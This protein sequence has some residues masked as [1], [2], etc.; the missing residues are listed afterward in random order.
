MNIC[1]LRALTL[2]NKLY[3][4]TVADI[5]VAVG[6]DIFVLLKRKFSPILQLSSIVLGSDVGVYVG[7]VV[8]DENG[9]EWYICYESGFVAYSM[10]GERRKL[11]YEFNRMT[12]VRQLTVGERESFGYKKNKLKFKYQE[13]I[14]TLL[15]IVGKYNDDMLT[16]NIPGRVK[17][18]D[19]QQD[20]LVSLDGK[21]VYL[22]DLYRGFPVLMCH[23]RICIQNE[24]GVYDIL[25][26]SY[27]TKMRGD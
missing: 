1:S 20:L 5:P 16:Q 7:D 23:G 12:V 19:V 26:G 2:D 21:R 11:L 10:V 13:F 8:V 24:F 9:D 17:T 18:S 3:T 22:G 14:F 15:D 27:I 4:F 25:E 6:E